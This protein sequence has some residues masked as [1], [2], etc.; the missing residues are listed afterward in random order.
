[1]QLDITKLAM[2]EDFN[3]YEISNSRSNLGDNAAA[4]TWRNAQAA[5]GVHC[6]LDTPEKIQEFKL[7]LRDFGAWEREEIE[8]WDAEETNALLLQIIAGDIREA[9]GDADFS[10]W[11]WEK[12]QADAESGRTSS[13]L[14]RAD[15]GRIY[16]TISN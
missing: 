14:F 15:D 5:A 6:F 11:D 4:I 7:F 16:Y 9:F 2:G 13:N 3:P 10:E 8:A 12:Y 1:M